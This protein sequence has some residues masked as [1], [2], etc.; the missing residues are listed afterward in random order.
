MNQPKKGK[1]ICFFLLCMVSEIG[2]WKRTYSLSHPNKFS[3]FWQHRAQNISYK[4][5]EWFLLGAKNYNHLFR[6][7]V[8]A[9][10]KKP[11]II[12]PAVCNQ[13][14][15]RSSQICLLASLVGKQSEHLQ[16]N[17]HIYLRIHEHLYYYKGVFVKIDAQSLGVRTQTVALGIWRVLFIST[18]FHARTLPT[19]ICFLFVR[20][21]FAQKAFVH[22]AQ[23]IISPANLPTVLFHLTLGAEFFY[24]YAATRFEFF[25]NFIRLTHMLVQ[26]ANGVWCSTP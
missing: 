26:M 18:S 17:K 16:L 6:R 22:S 14:S 25:F 13:L 5:S 8:C 2:N 1:I 3:S 23:R 9:A 12:A 21:M 15:T 20:V 7:I 4:S 10:V 11:A 24:L 19:V